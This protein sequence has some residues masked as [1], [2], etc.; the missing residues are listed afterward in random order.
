[1]K[2]VDVLIVFVLVVILGLGGTACVNNAD[3]AIPSDNYTSDPMIS[4]VEISEDASEEE[5]QIV[6]AIIFGGRNMNDSDSLDFSIRYAEKL[7]NRY[8][9]KI[10]SEEDAKEKAEIGWNQLE[11]FTVNEDMK[12][13]VARF[14][15]EYGVWYI[16]GKQIEN[17]GINSEGKSY[18][19][20][21][22]TSQIIIRESDGKV[23][24]I[25]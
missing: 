1:M 21:Y 8:L 11:E 23:L 14:I 7:L 2:K 16:T 18:W 6:N 3:D 22:S 4:K 12:P 20:P 19:I 13:F 24:A 5:K 25:W 17:T 15:D 9:G 10:T